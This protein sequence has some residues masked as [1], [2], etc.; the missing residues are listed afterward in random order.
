MM[1]QIGI[2]WTDLDQ[3]STAD[4]TITVLL[5]Q[6]LSSA[7]QFSNLPFTM[8]VACFYEVY[9]M[10]KVSVCVQAAGPMFTTEATPKIKVTRERPDKRKSTT[11]GT[12]K[13]PKPKV[14]IPYEGTKISVPV[15][16]PRRSKFASVDNYIQA[17]AKLYINL[18]VPGY[19]AF[20]PYDFTDG[21]TE[22]PYTWEIKTIEEKPKNKWGNDIKGVRSTLRTEII[23]DPRVLTRDDLLK[24]TIRCA[25]CDFLASVCT[26]EPED[27]GDR[28]INTLNRLSASREYARRLETVGLPVRRVLKTTLERKPDLVTPH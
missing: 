17:L 9:Y 20:R 26:T 28:P 27:D 1:E 22:T 24:M 2:H 6:L 25:V 18:I 12:G 5:T 4:S 23:I 19:T 10:K 7:V 16:E 15:I 13:R 21:Y 11:R 14:A 3:S 8:L